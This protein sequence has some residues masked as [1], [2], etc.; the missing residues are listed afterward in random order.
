VAVCSSPVALVTVGLFIKPLGVVYGWNR[1]SVALAISIG[2]IALA[3]STP[4]AGRLIDRFGVRR[5]LLGSLFTYGLAVALVPWCVQALGLPGLYAIYIAI[6]VLSSGSNTIAYARLLTGWFHHSRG[7]ALGIGMS[8]IPLGMAIT[9][10]LGQYL[11]EHV[12]WQGA[13]LGLAALPVLIGIPLALFAVRETPAAELT[14]TVAPQA[15]RQGMTRQQAMHGRAFWTLLMVFLLLACAMNGIELHI[16]PLLSDRGF[17]PMVAALAL[18]LLNVVAIGARVG[19]GFLFDRWFAPRVG[20]VL[21][22]L[23]L[24]ATV[25]L[26]SREQPWAAYA[27]AVMLGFGIGAE[28][29]LLGYLI[30]RYFGLKAYGELFGWIFGAFMVGTA[31]GPYLFGLGY[32]AFGNYRL[33]LGCA[34]WALAAVCVLLW[35]M[36]RYP[37]EL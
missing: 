37:R 32:D 25:L 12:S 26:S 17:S 11:I 35:W 33:P 1:A 5:I 9:S 31:A 13:F 6:G 19:A 4:L 15:D 2:A 10:P 30:G 18:S 22:A 20:A 36:P 8:G 14:Q 27:A 24:L 29:D 16:V 28:S 3:L 21:F 34:T 7:L 23:P